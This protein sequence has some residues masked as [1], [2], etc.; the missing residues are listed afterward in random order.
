M[1]SSKTALT[2]RLHDLF[3]GVFLNIVSVYVKATYWSINLASILINI[4]LMVH[5]IFKI[6]KSF[7]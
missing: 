3:L 5:R 6:N 2:K 7:F 4:F 1:R